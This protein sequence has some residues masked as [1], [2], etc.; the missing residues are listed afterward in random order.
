MS[1]LTH[2]LNEISPADEAGLIV[3]VL[4]DSDLL[5]ILDLQGRSVFGVDGQDLVGILLSQ[6][7]VLA[8]EEGV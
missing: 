4:T 3:Y 8:I 6:R 1:T 7:L 5:Q 2:S